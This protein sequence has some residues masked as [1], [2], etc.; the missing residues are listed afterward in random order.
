MKR[1]AFLAGAGAALAAC[2]APEPEPSRTA[3]LLAS[4]SVD[5]RAGQT[6]AVAF[7]GTQITGAV[8]EMIRLRGIGGVVLRAENAPDASA[9]ARICADLQRIAAEAKIPPLFLALDQEGG[10]VARIGTGMTIFPSQMALAATPDPT[11]AVQRAATITAGELRA[12]GI[13]WNFAPVADVNNEPLNPIIGN[14]SFGSDPQRVSSLVAAAVRAYNGAGFLCCAKHFPGH[15]AATIDSHV[16]LPLIDVDR[17]RLDRVELPPFRAAIAAGVPAVMLAHL[18]VPALDPTPQ[19]PASLSRRVTTDLLRRE[20]SFAGIAVTDD[21]EMGALSGVGQAA[22]GEAAVKA[23]ADFV[24][25]RFDE[26]AQREGH[27][28]ITIAI[29]N[30]SLPNL[31]STLTRLFDTKLRYGILDPVSPRPPDLTA[32]AAAALDLARGS[33]TVVHNDGKALP[34]RGR[35]YAIATTRADLTP[36]AGDSDLATE[37]QRARGDVGHRTFGANISDAVIA[38]ALEEARNADVVVAGVADIG[39]NDDQLRL[40]TRLAA[41]RPT[42]LVS[43]RGPYDV[44]FVGNVAACV[45]AYDGRLPSLRAVVEVITGARKPVGTLPVTVSDRYP[46]GAGLRDFA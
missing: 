44:R 4:L 22:A 30:N 8:E 17:A 41:T 11:A 31:D 18:I 6:M 34:L 19:L 20:L 35:V 39:I 36:L 26:E 5:Q 38:T 3:K 25:F 32:N 16:G 12:S 40:V 7:H 10:G 23:G 2:A 29:R 33:I 9:L 24:L 43:L 27:R 21:L 28:L 42:V 14:R 46:I 37:L 45:C 15:G 13:N 1:R